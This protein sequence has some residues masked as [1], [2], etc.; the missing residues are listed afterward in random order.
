MHD[1]L[2][3]EFVLDKATGSKTD[4]IVT[5]PTKT[6]YYIGRVGQ[7]T[8]GH[9]AVPA[10]LQ[11]D[12][13]LRRRQLVRYDREERTVKTPGSF[14]P[15]PPTV[16]DSICWEANVITFNSSNV[17]G[18]KNVANINTTFENGWMSMNFPLILSSV[19]PIPYSAAAHQ[20]GGSSRRRV[21]LF[22]RVDVVRR[23]GDVLR[24]AGHRLRGVDVQQR[25]RGWRAVELRRQ[26][27]PQVHA[28]RLARRTIASP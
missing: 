18:S 19:G 27:H 15:P 28:R 24:P 14:S 16:K 17:F 2:Y 6:Y 25:Q 13:C 9:Q 5:M 22:S 1:N 11:V 4:W 7:G 23:R 12:R 20:L 10:Q 26:L 3:N 8:E 21:D